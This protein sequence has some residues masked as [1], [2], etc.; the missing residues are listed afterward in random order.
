VPAP[1][2][3]KNISQKSLFLTDIIPKVKLNNQV[4]LPIEE[5]VK[6]INNSNMQILM[7]TLSVDQQ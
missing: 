4:Y 3:R 1:R 2:L 7:Q 6:T 5:I